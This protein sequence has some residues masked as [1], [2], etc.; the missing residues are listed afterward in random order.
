MKKT[1]LLACL[2]LATGMQAKKGGYKIVNLVPETPSQAPDYM[3]TWNLQGYAVSYTGSNNLRLAM[4]EE[5]IFGQA[6]GQRWVNMFPEIHQDLWFLLD[7]SWDIPKDDAQNN[8]PKVGL[9]ELDESRFPSFKGTP[10]ERFRHLSDSLK[11]Y[12]WRGLGLWVSAQK[13]ACLPDVSDEDFWTNRL[14]VA[15]AAGVGYWKIDWGRQSKDHQWRRW[16]SEKARREAPHLTV[17]QAMNNA[18]VVFSD[19]YRTYDVENIIAQPITIDR[20]CQLLP[21]EA[22]AE[23]K[24]IVNCEDEP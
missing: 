13:A 11:A 1:M 16:L 8:S 23:A 14:Q 18:N 3:C 12:G 22:E 9:D 19:T 4:N 24:G 21:Y 2:L 10:T 5:Y 7:D 17:E 20:V 15:E 6:Y